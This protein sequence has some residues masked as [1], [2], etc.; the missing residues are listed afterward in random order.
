M[1]LVLLCRL[2]LMSGRWPESWKVHWICPIHKKLS[3]H[4]PGHYRG[5]QLT[6]QISK[7]AER[8]FSSLFVPRL[9]HE[10]RFGEHQFAYTPGR[11][12]RDALL[13]LVMSWLR[14]FA[15]RQRVA[16]YCSDVAGAFDRVSATRLCAKLAAACLPA[17]LLAVLKDWLSARSAR[18]VV[19]GAVS[20]TVHM[21]DMIYQ[22]TVFGPPLWN[23]FSLMLNI[24]FAR[25]GSEKLL[26]QT[27]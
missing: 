1:P 12:A 8:L 26:L 4:M 6:A 9:F 14:A 16:V 22:G 18:V 7:A 13:F 15:M 25:A 5:V 2:I 20:R 21:A 19:D 24:Q 17:S 27:T 10:L 11:G 23:V 3:R